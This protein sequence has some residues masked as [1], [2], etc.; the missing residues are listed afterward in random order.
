M[1]DKFELGELA[2]AT[3]VIVLNKLACAA[4]VTA[5]LFPSN[6]LS[7][8][9]TYL[10]LIVIHCANLFLVKSKDYSCLN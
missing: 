5:I 9:L 8:D 6:D 4:S 1:K 10:S 7:L 3:R 2:H